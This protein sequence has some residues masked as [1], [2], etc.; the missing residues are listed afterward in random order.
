MSQD[1]HGKGAGGELSTVTKQMLESNTLLESFGNAQTLRNNNSSRFGKFMGLK[2]DFRGAIRGGNI[3]TYLLE[4]SRVVTHIA[5][6]RNF[7]VFHM[8]T[9]GS[10]AE[11]AATLGLGGGEEQFRYL[12]NVHSDVPGRDEVGEFEQLMRSMEVVGIM[13]EQRTTVCRLLAAILHLGNITMGA[14]AEGNAV[15]IDAADQTTAVAEAARL[16]GLDGREA[17][18]TRALCNRT[19]SVKAGRRASVSVVPLDLDQATH[20]RDSLSKVRRP[21]ANLYTM[22]SVV[23]VLVATYVSG[24]LQVLFSVC[25]DMT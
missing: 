15:I 11:M 2:L 23:C 21:R 8:I 7:H 12:N 19:I 9:S 24:I 17:F 3:S 10:G 6:E 22:F 25:T 4:K 14:D 5:G 18:L 16:L 1:P 13:E 20:S